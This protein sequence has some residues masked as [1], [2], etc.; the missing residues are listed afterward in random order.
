MNNFVRKFLN[1]FCVLRACSCII[2]IKDLSEKHA[3]VM[4]SLTCKVLFALY[5]DIQTYVHK[6]NPIL[7]AHT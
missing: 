5:I 1:I 4:K 3:V 6:L 7:E 2:E